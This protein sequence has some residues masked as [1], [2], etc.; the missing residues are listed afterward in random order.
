MVVHVFSPALEGK[1]DQKFKVS[2]SYT[3]RLG[4]LIQNKQNNKKE[5]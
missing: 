3:V 2:L 4:T 5:L 1:E